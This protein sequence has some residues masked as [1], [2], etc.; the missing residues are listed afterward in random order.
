MAETEPEEPH[1]FSQA[2]RPR[3]EMGFRVLS[4]FGLALL[5]FLAGAITTFYD[6]FPAREIGRALEG[7]KALYEKLTRY[8][9][10][11][12]SDLW[13]PERR[14]DKGV[15]VNLAGKAQDGITLYT[16]GNGAAAYLI[17]MRG[18]VLHEWR[19]RFSTVWKKG[20]G[21]VKRPQPDS[22]VYFRHA[23]VFPNGDLLALYEGVGDTPYGYGLVK[24]DRN[25]NVIWSYMGRTHHQFDVA[26]D[27]KIYVLTHEI[28]D[29][30]L[31]KFGHLKSPRIEDFLVVLSPDGKELRKVRLLT[32]LARSKY[33]HLLNTVSSLALGD[34]LH[35]NSVSY[36]DRTAAAN[37]AH[38][39]EGQIL[40][41]FRETNAIVVL[42]LDKQD[43]VWAKRGPWIGQHDPD[44]L[45]NGN[46]LLFDNYANYE[47]AEGVSRVLE[48]DSRTM[49]IVWQYRGTAERP[50]QSLIRADQQRLPN[51]NT[52]ITESNGGRILEVA[53]DGQIV[54]EF[55]NPVRGGKDGRLIPI[56]AWSQRLD[57]TSLDPGLLARPPRLAPPAR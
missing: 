44:I 19:R 13:H 46:I 26:P 6:V 39:K 23:H 37:F 12:K 2:R 28:V 7:G 35:A 43:F 56:V 3:M 8:Q 4:L 34:P 41:S 22:H 21:G 14:A 36:I 45:P 47:G 16:S 5:I 55:L 49:R 48:F 33:R 9:D 24:L 51:G 17:D 40:L 30:E 29:K 57:P 1:E 53:R 31:P 18:R 38:G 27:G 54:W 52:L 20:G 10:V 25:S 42:D 32:V 11:Y 15:T 50:L